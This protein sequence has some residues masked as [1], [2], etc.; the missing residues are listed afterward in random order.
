MTDKEY[1]GPRIN[2]VWGIVRYL[3]STV[4]L[5]VTDNEARLQKKGS[6]TKTRAMSNIFHL[7]HQ[8]VTYG[9]WVVFRSLTQNTSNSQQTLT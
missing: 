2:V 6:K 1:T 8:P 3:L 9:S 7:Y 4:Y 5:P